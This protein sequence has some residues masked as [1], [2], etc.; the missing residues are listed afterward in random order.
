[1]FICTILGMGNSKLYSDKPPTESLGVVLDVIAEELERLKEERKGIEEKMAAL[2]DAHNLIVDWSVDL[3]KAV[4]QADADL[5]MTDRIREILMA[6]PPRGFQPT[7]V[8]NDLV[9]AGFSLEGR[10]NP[11]AEVHTVLRRLVASGEATE[12]DGYYAW[13]GEKQRRTKKSKAG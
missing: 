1:M 9:R 8:R 10:S 7:D 2:R 4:A 13:I 12:N 5:G 6:D 11:M 3:P